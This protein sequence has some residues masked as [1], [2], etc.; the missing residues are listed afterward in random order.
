MTET[1]LWYGQWIWLGDC[2][3][4]TGECFCWFHST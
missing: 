4:K 3:F 1:V 2:R